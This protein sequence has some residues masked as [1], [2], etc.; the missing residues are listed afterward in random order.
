M[1]LPTD[2]FLG[3]DGYVT[4]MRSWTE[5]FDD[6]VVEAEKVVD[7]DNDRVVAIARAYGTGK[8]SGAHVELRYGAVHTLEAHRIVRVDIFPRPNDA[9]EAATLRK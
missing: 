2:G 8:G 9:F 3:R 7:A 4:F 6:F 1:G 5:D